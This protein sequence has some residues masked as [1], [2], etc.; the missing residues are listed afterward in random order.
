MKKL[1]RYLAD[2]KKECFLGQL[3]KMLEATF[4]LFV[5]LVVKS[6][7][8]KGIGN[9]DTGHII[10]M[11]LLMALLAAIGLTNT[12]FAQYFAAKAATGFSA[13]LR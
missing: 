5:P 12:I 9:H 4:E 1:L 11:C 10:R 13:K 7:I 6:M 3:F 2:Y 8:D